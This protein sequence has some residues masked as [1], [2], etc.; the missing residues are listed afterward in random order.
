[1]G[2]MMNKKIMEINPYNNIIKRINEKVSGDSTVGLEQKT[3]NDLIHLLYD[4]TLQSSGFSLEDPASFSNR[5]LKLINIGLGVEEEDVGTEVEESVG[6][7]AVK[8]QIV[9]STM[10]EVD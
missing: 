9:E 6:S 5:I 7:E 10:E 2:F 4:I 1:M 3:L 8:E